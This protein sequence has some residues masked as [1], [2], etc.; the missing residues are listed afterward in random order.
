MKQTNSSSQFGGIGFNL[1]NKIDLLKEKS[2]SVVYNLDEN[3]WN[4][5]CTLQ[6][7][8]KDIKPE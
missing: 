2:V 8:I 5:K 1:G 7:R 3:E 4:G 6:L